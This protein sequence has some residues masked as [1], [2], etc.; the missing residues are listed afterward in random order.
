MKDIKDWTK[1]IADLAVMGEEQVLET[2]SDML[3][4]A[5]DIG[6]KVPDA[7]LIETE[8]ATELRKVIPSLH[9]G[10]MKH[11]AAAKAEAKKK[12]APPTK[13]VKKTA[14]KAAKP[15]TEKMAK[16][17]KK[18]AVK[19]AKKAAKSA[20]PAKKA[21]AKKAAKANARTGV[22]RSPF[23]ENATIRV[24][25]K[26]NPARADSERGKRI[27][28]VFKMNGKKVADFYKLAPPLNRTDTLRFLIDRDYITVK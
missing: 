21:A 16:T 15:E 23:P 22:A 25:N 5:H 7:Q 10:L 26:E 2:Y 19:P 28:A 12:P 3:A 13:P 8:D 9:E 24:L 20:K 1:A 6:Y 11:H 18:A 14:Q 4:T 17:A 27:A